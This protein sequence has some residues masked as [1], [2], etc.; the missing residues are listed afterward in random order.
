MSRISA[1]ELNTPKGA[2]VHIVFHTAQQD[3]NLRNTN[4]NTNGYSNGQDDKEATVLLE[5]THSTMHT[6]HVSSNFQS[7]NFD[8]NSSATYSSSSPRNNNFNSHKLH[9]TRLLD[10][11]HPSVFEASTAGQARRRVQLC[12]IDK[13]SGTTPPTSSSSSS[14]SSPAA[15]R[16]AIVFSWLPYFLHWPLFWFPFNV[17]AT[18]ARVVGAFTTAICIVIIIFRGSRW[19][20]YV[21]LGLFADFTARFFLGGRGSLLGVLSEIVTEVLHLKV[22]WY[23]GCS[24]QFAALCGSMF[25]GFASLAFFVSDDSNGIAGSVVTGVLMGC[26]FLEAVFDF[27]VGCFCFSYGVQF[28]LV[29]SDGFDR[30]RATLEEFEE[31]RTYLDTRFGDPR[32]DLQKHYVGGDWEKTGQP[33]SLVY[34]YKPSSDITKK[35]F[36]HPIRNIHSGYFAMS[37]GVTGL[38][39]QWFVTNQVFGHNKLIWQS[40]AVFGGVLYGLL[41]LLYAAKFVFFNKKVRKE[42]NHPVYRYT[43]F[44]IPLNL[45]LFIPLSVGNYFVFAQ[46]LFW[47]AA[48]FLL[49]L[50]CL[51]MSSW[52]TYQLDFDYFHPGWCLAPLS[53]VVAA[54]V[55]PSVY[56]AYTSAAW[57]WLAVSMFFWFILTTLSIFRLAFYSP[58]DDK[59]RP[60]LFM[61]VS[62][63]NLLYVCYIAV[64]NSAD[65][66]SEFVYFVGVVLALWMITLGLQAYFGRTRFGMDYWGFAFPLDTM[67]IA[68][69]VHHS[70]HNSPTTEG[71][72]TTAI[73]IA[74]GVISVLV[75]HTVLAIVQRSIFIPEDK[76]APQSAFKIQ[77]FAFKHALATLVQATVPNRIHSIDEVKQI[78]QTFA[79]FNLTL[80]EH[81]L[82]EENIIFPVFHD[83]FAGLTT[84]ADKEHDAEVNECQQILSMT[85]QLL[86]GP[87]PTKFE[88]DNPEWR[89][90]E[91]RV[92]VLHAALKQLEQSIV[93]HIDNE[94]T[95]I[96]P[97]VRKYLNLALHKQLVRKAWEYTPISA[98][99]VIIP[100]T[101]EHQ[102][103][104]LRRVRFL[105]ALRWAVPEQMHQIGRICYE[106]LKDPVL[107]QRLCVDVPELAPRTT[108]GYQRFY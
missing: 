98:W 96:A 40:L 44:L 102:F 42:W 32:T 37:V 52:V 2:P 3:N 48:P 46:V 57:L 87:L 62:A 1:V 71:I 35:E 24:K 86:S 79:R 53:N 59:V 8:K 22:H 7:T 91:Q 39:V 74:N 25:T 30:S 72:A 26:A 54:Y 101:L 90:F 16:D 70:V 51:T 23:P 4:S 104:H 61:L 106:G 55:F 13:L 56:P 38:A 92:A 60:M 63:P 41:L 75:A 28:G 43:L 68:T 81:A 105:Q 69:A 21:N 6:D 99:R 80:N 78:H 10:L 17:N 27:C 34:E 84:S 36:F 76:W 45:L 31:T 83:W 100:F 9:D 108:P 95:N 20:W 47:I 88:D 14:S 97:A 66:F 64:T 11:T 73:V 29:S 58:L 18:A 49:C 65:M 89:A 5:S 67:A 85:S 93:A 33:R 94:E 82:T 15:T 50:T 12:A 19:A 77:H 103:I 107:F